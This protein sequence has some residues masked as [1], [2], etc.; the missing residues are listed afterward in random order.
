MAAEYDH[1]LKLVLVGETGV[2][3]SSILLR[4]TDGVFEPESTQSTIGVDFRLKMMRVGGK[5][6]KVTIWDTAG[7]SRRSTVSYGCR[8]ATN[9]EGDISGSI[10]HAPITV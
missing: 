4:F 10:E 1:L 3:K 7:Q 8:R 2:G 5:L 9:T 6:C